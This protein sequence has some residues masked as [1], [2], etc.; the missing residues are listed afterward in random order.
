MIAYIWKLTDIRQVTTMHTHESRADVCTHVEGKTSR[1]HKTATDACMQVDRLSGYADEA[2]IH[3][4]LVMCG[5]DM[6]TMQT[7]VQISRSGR[8]HG[9][10]FATVN[11]FRTLIFSSY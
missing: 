7:I 5:A 9:F 11:V 2:S 8:K 1:R 3:M 6:S 4:Y 10:T